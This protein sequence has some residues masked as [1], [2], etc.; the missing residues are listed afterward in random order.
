MG[1]PPNWKLQSAIFTGANYVPHNPASPKPQ[2]RA[3]PLARPRTASPVG[4]GPNRVK[5]DCEAR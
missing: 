3:A 4:D 2:D 1:F 5:A